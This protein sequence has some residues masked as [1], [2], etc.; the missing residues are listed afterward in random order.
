[1]YAVWLEEIVQIKDRFLKNN[2]K[3]LPGKSQVIFNEKQ[4][5]CAG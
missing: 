3:I 5:L 1:M 2:S 4:G